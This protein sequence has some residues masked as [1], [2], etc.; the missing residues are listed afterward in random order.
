MTRATCATAT[1]L[2]AGKPGRVG[3]SRRSLQSPRTGIA[4][5][6]KLRHTSL[7]GCRP[8]HRAANRSLTLLCADHSHNAALTGPRRDGGPL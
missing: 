4:H 3:S 5:L 1:L 6:R 2:H 7:S 8:G